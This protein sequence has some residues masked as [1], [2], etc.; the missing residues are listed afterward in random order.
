MRPIVGLKVSPTWYGLPQ[1]FLINKKI[2]LAYCYHELITK[3]SGNQ[4]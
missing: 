4:I 2:Q 3:S 1:S